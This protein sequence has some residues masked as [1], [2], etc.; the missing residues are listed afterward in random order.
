[1]PFGAHEA[2]ETHEVLVTKKSLIENTS[3]YMTMVQ[4]PALRDMMDRQRQTMVQMYNEVVHYT[5]DYSRPTMNPV[6]QGTT[7]WSTEQIQYGLRNPMPEA[8]SM[9]GRL[10]EL[11][12]SESLLIGHKNSAKT[13]MQAALEAADPNLRQMMINGSIACANIAYEIFQF[14]N[15]RGFYQVPTLNDQTAKTWMHH[16]Q[17]VGQ[18][19]YGGA[20]GMIHMAGANQA[21]QMNATHNANADFAQAAGYGTT[22]HTGNSSKGTGLGTSM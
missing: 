18:P 16:Y 6:S 14:M 13:H 10:D 5:H 12:I 1:M 20:S 3:L 2:M 4:D 21:G 9:N 7:H 8:P 19:T 17:A 22:H 11:T 15:R